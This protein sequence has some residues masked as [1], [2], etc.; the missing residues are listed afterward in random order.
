[1][2]PGSVELRN[3]TGSSGYAGPQPPSGA[4][5]YR[6]VLYAMP[7]AELTLTEGADKQRFFPAVTKALGA[8]TLDATYAR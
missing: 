6:F 2:P 3:D 7:V 8:V 1:M 4:H 5:V